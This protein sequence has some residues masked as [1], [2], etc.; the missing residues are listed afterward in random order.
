VPEVNLYILYPSRDAVSE[1]GTLE[2]VVVTL[3]TTRPAENETISVYVFGYAIITI[4]EPPAPPVVAV[5]A[6]VD[7]PPPPPVFVVPATPL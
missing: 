4:P 7:P 6:A 1:V 2:P 3:L 5:V